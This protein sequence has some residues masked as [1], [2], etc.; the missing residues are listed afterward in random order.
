MD[1]KILDTAIPIIVYKHVHTGPNNFL[2]GI[3]DG[4][5]ILL[6]QPPTFE[7]LTT[8]GKPA[9]ANILCPSIH[10]NTDGIDDKNDDDTDGTTTAAA[11]AAAA[12]FNRV[13]LRVVAIDVVV[14]PIRS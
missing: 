5:S 13:L 3:H 14:K 7:P 1:E 8:N 10:H 2:F 6:Y 4:K 12:E 11:A 9:F